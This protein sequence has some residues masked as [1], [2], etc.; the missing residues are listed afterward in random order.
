MVN[1]RPVFPGSEK[2][3]YMSGR[4][5]HPLTLTLADL[6][7]EELDGTVP[8]SFCGGADANSFPDLVADGLGPVTVCT[9][10]LKP[11][12]YARLQQTW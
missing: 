1:H 9:D 3:M 5:L 4:S 6:V 12:G 10:L 11:G 7:T 8:I 2:M